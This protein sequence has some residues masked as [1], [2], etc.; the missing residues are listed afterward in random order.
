[1]TRKAGPQRGSLRGR[2]AGGRLETVG[3]EVGRAGPEIRARVG[4]H[5]SLPEDSQARYLTSGRL[6]GSEQHTLPAAL[7][8][9]F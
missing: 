5:L 7:V 2:D 3:K 1:M 8:G 4:A 9:L 6:L